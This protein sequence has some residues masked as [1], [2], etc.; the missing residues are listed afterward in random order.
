[1]SL[2]PFRVPRSPKSPKPHPKPIG[3]SRPIRF[4]SSAYYNPSFDPTTHYGHMSASTLSESLDLAHQDAIAA[5]AAAARRLSQNTV[6][7]EDDTIAST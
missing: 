3:R 4:V 1:M 6:S 2:S 7:D 5:Q